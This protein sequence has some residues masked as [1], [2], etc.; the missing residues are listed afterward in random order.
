MILS[1]A[2]IKHLEQT[3]FGKHLETFSS[4]FSGTWRLKEVMY[5]LQDYENTIIKRISVHV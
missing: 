4:I 2:Q 3:A 5:N 1:D